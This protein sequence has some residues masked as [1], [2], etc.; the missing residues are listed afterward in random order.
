MYL[1]G[2]LLTWVGE[3]QTVA[4]GQSL[5]VCAAVGHQTPAVGCG[6]FR[7]WADH[8]CAK[9]NVVALKQSVQT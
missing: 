7:G 3:V 6:R 2:W 8:M 1:M 4:M 5:S 9:G